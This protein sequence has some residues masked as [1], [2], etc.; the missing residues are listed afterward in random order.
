MTGESE[1]CQLRCGDHLLDLSRPRVM[2]VLNVTPDSFSDG[3]RFLDPGR[4]A[5]RA[6]EMVAEGAAL[7]DLGG[8]S[9]RP[10]APPVSLEEE[11]RRVL[12]VLRRLVRELAVPV[13]VDTLKPAL[14]REAVAAGAGLINDVN[15]LRAPGALEAIADSDAAVCL[16]HMQG[17]P[18]TMQAAPEYHDVVSE[19]SA[20]L[21][22]RVAS[23]DA[24]G[25]G[26]HRLLLDPGF[27]FGKLDA[28]N[29]ALLRGLPVLVASGVPILVGLSRKSM[30]GRLLGREVPRRL[31]GSL[32]L[33]LA[34]VARG[35]RVVRAHDVA[36]T[37]D[38]LAI[39]RLAG[40]QTQGEEA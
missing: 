38:A 24:A 19:V 32:A 5:A 35:A 11:R 12:P 3:G 1:R 20:F 4:A 13:S 21:Q 7:I 16:M 17:E 15:A 37:A 36:E 14:M 6:A 8:E 26:R 28:H 27:G 18:R 29:L 30:I 23:C 2:G 10:G 22:Q 33:A 40:V 39:W 25:I 34:A 31:A 9:T